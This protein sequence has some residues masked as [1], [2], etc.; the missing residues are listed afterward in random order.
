MEI[1]L[2]TNEILINNRPQSI[3]DPR[4]FLKLTWYANAV[5]AYFSKLMQLYILEYKIFS[6]DGN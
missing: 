3:H 5:H 1:N 2:S 4:S 6:K